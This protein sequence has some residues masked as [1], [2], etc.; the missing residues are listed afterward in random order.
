MLLLVLWFLEE[1]NEAYIYATELVSHYDIG[2]GIGIG[3]GRIMIIIDF[4]STLISTG[5]ESS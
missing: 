2:I 1:P 4:N 5:L 3:I